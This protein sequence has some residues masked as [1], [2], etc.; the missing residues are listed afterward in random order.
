MVETPWF[1]RSIR[2]ALAPLA[3]TPVLVAATAAGSADRPWAPPP[4]P[5]PPRVE[6]GTERVGR[7]TWYRAD[8]VLVDGELRANRVTLG[9]GPS[10]P[11]AIVLDAES[12][13]AGPFGDALLLGTDDGVRS[14]LTLVDVPRG[15]AWTLA[16]SADVIRRATIDPAGRRIDEQRVDRATRA[17]LGIWRRDVAAPATATRAV[18]PIA[19]DPRFGRTFSTE[20]AWSPDGQR[21]AVTS[22]GAAACR[23]RV[24]DPAT[25]RVAS[26]VDPMLGDLVGLDADRVIVHGA[27]PG[28]PCPIVS[29]PTRGGQRVVLARDAGLASLTVGPDGS[30]RVVMEVLGRGWS[31]RSIAP[32]GGAPVDLGPLPADQRLVPGGGRASS[33]VALPPGWTATAPDGHL[34]LAPR[35]AMA[36]HITDGRAVSLDEV[37]R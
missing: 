1:R 3:L 20:L 37:P 9:H 25:G 19:P 34:P 2:A 12:F 11:R 7:G 24:L 26:I 21:L 13:A 30:T 33:G 4:C 36:R 17:D 8:P 28:L 18:E 31:L 23:I 35:S 16:T 15:C 14:T 5:D 29:V 6:V 22:C 32:D 27:C 10:R